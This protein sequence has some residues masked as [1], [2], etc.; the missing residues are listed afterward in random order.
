MKKKP[1]YLFFIAMFLLSF[2]FFNILVSSILFLLKQSITSINVIIA[3]ILS[4]LLMIY[5][6]KKD[7]NYKLKSFAIT[8]AVPISIIIGTTFISGKVYDYSWDGNSYHK[9]TIGILS[10][11]WNPVYETMKE[12]DLLAQY[13]LYPHSS[14]LQVK[15]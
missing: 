11:G 14:F 9:S 1:N 6:L 12:F 2:I 5:T 7:D 10:D 3:M 13:C 4:I 15:I 8:I